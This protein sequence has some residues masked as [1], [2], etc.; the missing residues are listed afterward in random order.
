M[1]T[2][3]NQG[4]K[5]YCIEESNTMGCELVTGCTDLTK[6]R[7]KL[8]LINLSLMDQTQT[9]S[10]SA[11]NVSGR[12]VPRKDDYVRWNRSTGEVDEGG[13]ISK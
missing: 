12:Y 5:Y 10:E 11:L 13:F 3:S 6:D 8:N 4:T 2:S 9:T 7:H 1:T